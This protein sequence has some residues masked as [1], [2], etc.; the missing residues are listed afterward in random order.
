MAM[1]EIV[2]SKLVDKERNKEEIEVTKEDDAPPSSLINSIVNMKWKQRKS[3]EAHS[4]ARNTLGV[5]GRAGA[6][7]WD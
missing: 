6:P 2:K 7:E 5:Q 1:R 3:K 4:L